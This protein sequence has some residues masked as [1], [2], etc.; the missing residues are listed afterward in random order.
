MAASAPGFTVIETSELQILRQR[1]A[2]LELQVDWLM[3]EKRES[4]RVSEEFLRQLRHQSFVDFPP[5]YDEVF[6][7]H[8]SQPTRYAFYPPP[9]RPPPPPYYTPRRCRQSTPVP[10]PVAS[11][12]LAVLASMASARSPQPMAAPA[13]PAPVPPAPG[14]LSYFMLGAVGV[15]NIS[16]FFRISCIAMT[17]VHKIFIALTAG[18]PPFPPP[19]AARGR[20]AAVRARART[21]DMPDWVQHADQSDENEPLPGPS[22]ASTAVTRTASGLE[23]HRVWQ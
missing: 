12:P 20:R 3:R 5:T 16:I 10:Q 13:P 4:F 2:K 14:C 1:I 8:Y 9:P 22:R 7:Q 18:R 17:F 19:R 11:S 23:I 6:G 21:E 15:V